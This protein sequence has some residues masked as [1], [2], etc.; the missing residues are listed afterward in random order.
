M[1]TDL[2]P[3]LPEELV[4]RVSGD[5]DIATV[6][7]LRAELRL[8]MAA[9]SGPVALDLAA[10]SF[11]DATGLGALVW[12]ANEMRARGRRASVRGAGPMT[13]RVLEITHVDRRF[14][15]RQVVPSW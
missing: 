11:I 9:G 7:A 1:R 4:H 14:A 2:T 13:S 5:L 10:V 8:T 15:T 6:G 3:Q 12:F